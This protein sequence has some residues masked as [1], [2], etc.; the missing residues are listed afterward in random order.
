M[1]IPGPCDDDLTW[2]T[3]KKSEVFIKDGAA[4]R[5]YDPFAYFKE[6]KP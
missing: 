1:L 2:F 5:G 6:A 4:I 3:H